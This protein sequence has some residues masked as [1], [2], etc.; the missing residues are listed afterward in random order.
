[1][2]MILYGVL[3]FIF[4]PLFLLV[5][6]KMKTVFPKEAFDKIKCKTGIL[7]CFYTFLVVIRFL[8]YVGLRM[9]TKSIIPDNVDN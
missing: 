5:F 6:I 8:C 2:L 1:M 4:I 3:T 9:I 7:F